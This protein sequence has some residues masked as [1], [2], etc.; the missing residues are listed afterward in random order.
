MDPDIVSFF[1]VCAGIVITVASLATIGVAARVI[2]LRAQ[3]SAQRPRIDDNRL[4]HLEQSV[5]AIAIEVERISEA[6]RF[7]T[8]LL[9]EKERESAGSSASLAE[10]R[11]RSV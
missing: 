8:K 11:S 2:L 9:T 7:A 3:R 6:Q 4:Q 1:Q 10:V 5:D